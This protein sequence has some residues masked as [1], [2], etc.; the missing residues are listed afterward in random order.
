MITGMDPSVGHLNSILARGGGNLN[1]NF[2]KSQMPG[3]GGN[4]KLRFDRYIISTLLI[5]HF[6]VSGV[7]D[8]LF[9]DANEICTLSDNFL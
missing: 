5:A 7:L 1:N 9:E 2:K 8:S 4:L 6:E 3:G